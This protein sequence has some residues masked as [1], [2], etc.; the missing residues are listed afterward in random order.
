ML[1]ADGRHQPAPGGQLGLESGRDVRAGGRGDVDGV[2]RRLLG[3]PLPAVAD[4]ADH[5]G[6]AQPR[7]RDPR[8]R[9]QLRVALHRPHLAGQQAQQRCVIPRPGADVEHPVRG[10]ELQQLEHPGHHHRLRDRL[11]AVD[12][13]G[14]VLIGPC[15]LGVWDEAVTGHRGDGV[16]HPLVVHRPRQQLRESLCRVHPRHSHRRRCGRPVLLLAALVGGGPIAAGQS[17]ARAEARK[18][19]RAGEGRRSTRPRCWP[20]YSRPRGPWRWRR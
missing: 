12:R 19:S 15:P 17:P 8:L 9:A 14:R 16:E 6:V 1:V 11:C 4:D 2:K 13:Q 7:Q 10:R 20:R 18:R 3:Q 5:V